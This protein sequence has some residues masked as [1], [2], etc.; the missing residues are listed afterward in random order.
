MSPTPNP[1][2]NA[3][4]TA[5]LIAGAA[6]VFDVK[7]IAVTFFILTCLCLTLVVCHSISLRRRQAEA[8]IVMQHDPAHFPHWPGVVATPTKGCFGRLRWLNSEPSEQAWGRVW[9]GNR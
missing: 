6:L 7:L 8:T 4:S 9:W 2:L 5:S 3:M 1:Y